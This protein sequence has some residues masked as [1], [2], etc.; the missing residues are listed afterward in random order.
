M[1]RLALRGTLTYSVF[2]THTGAAHPNDN[3]DTANG[4]HAPTNRYSLTDRNAAASY[5][6]SLAHPNESATHP[7]S[8]RYSD[9]Q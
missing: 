8:H 3:I 1:V 2:S 7:D 9:S 6:Y 4:D 5:Q